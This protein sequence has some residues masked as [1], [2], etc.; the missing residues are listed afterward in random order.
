VISCF[1][2]LVESAFGRGGRARGVCHS[3][4]DEHISKVFS[5]V[6]DAV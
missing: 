4:D 5:D 3:E 1:V 6:S 2:A